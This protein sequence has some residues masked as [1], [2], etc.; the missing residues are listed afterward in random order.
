M[1][2]WVRHLAKLSRV[3]FQKSGPVFRFIPST[4]QI[5]FRIQGSDQE[6]RGDHTRI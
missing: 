1:K 3:P 6:S 2:K 4:S 5:S